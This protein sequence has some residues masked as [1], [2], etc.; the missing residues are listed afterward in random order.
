MI[1]DDGSYRFDD[2]DLTISEKMISRF[3]HV[4]DCYDSVSGETTTER[5]FERGDWKVRTTTRT[6]LTATPTHFRI[7]AELDGYEG[8]TRV[9]TK[10]FQSEIDRDLV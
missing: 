4:Y 9:F 7:R 6:V 1:A 3:S 5:R 10:N 2:L 8:E